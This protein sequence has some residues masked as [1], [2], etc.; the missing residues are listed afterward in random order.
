[1][2]AFQARSNLRIRVTVTHA[3][4]LVPRLEDA[5]LTAT[6]SKMRYVLTVCSTD[7]GQMACLTV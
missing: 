3:S 5:V 7:S 6:M 1:M 2:G 4:A